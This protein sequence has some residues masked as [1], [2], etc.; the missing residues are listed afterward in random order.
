MRPFQTVAQILLIA[1]IANSVLAAPGSVPGRMQEEKQKRWSAETSKVVKENAVAGVVGGILS[2]IIG[3]IGAFATK[4]IY[5]G[6]PGSSSPSSSSSS[7]N[8]CVRPLLSSPF[9]TL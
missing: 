2:G 5:Q 3:T 4:V 9:P 6:L 8:K 7:G 1:S